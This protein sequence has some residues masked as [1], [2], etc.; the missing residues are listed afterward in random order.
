V[1]V[2]AVLATAVAVGCG[3]DE[4]FANEPRSPVTVELTGVIQADKL[5]VSPSKLGAGPVRITVSNQTERPYSVTLEGESTVQRSNTVNPGDT[6]TLQSTLAEGSYEVRAGSDT[7]MRKEIAPAVLDIGSERP[8][9]NND[10][11]LP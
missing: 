1:A 4:D 2:V 7:A 6:A 10:L 5:T 9:S 11:A 3:D 8:A